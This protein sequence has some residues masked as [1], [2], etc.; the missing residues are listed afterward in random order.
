MAD[1]QVVG[2]MLS[3][4]F[5]VGLIR[6]GVVHDEDLDTADKIIG[7]LDAQ[8]PLLSRGNQIYCRTWVTGVIRALVQQGFLKTSA[9]DEQVW[10]YIENFGK[11]EWAGAAQAI[12][13][14]P[15]GESTIF[16]C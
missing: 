14:R 4:L 13:P 6:I 2:D 8:V 10:E 12:Q 11:E 5:L 1:H 3:T 9:T 16:L 15:I 7:A